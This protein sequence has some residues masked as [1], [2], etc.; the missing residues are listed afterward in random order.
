M[1]RGIRRLILW[2]ALRQAKR[3]ENGAWQTFL[4]VEGYT[5]H[6]PD[7]SN[8]ALTLDIARQSYELAQQVFEILKKEYRNA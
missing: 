6:C 5:A 4:F 7:G 2:F 3:N 1:K 8:G